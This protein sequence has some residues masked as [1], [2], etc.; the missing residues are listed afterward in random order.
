MISVTGLSK[1]YNSFYALCDVSI[2]IQ[3][4]EIF[5]LLG[6]NG[7]GKTTLLNCL[8]GLLY[9]TAG[10]I[11]FNG[12]CRNKDSLKIKKNLFY[13]P[14]MPFIYP[15]WTPEKYLKTIGA[16][17]EVRQIDIKT[18]I[19]YLLEEFNI[20]GL[21]TTPVQFFSRG[22]F[23]KLAVCGALITDAK[24]LLFDE[25]FASGID[26]GGIINLKK[27]L[28]MRS[29]D[30]NA[31]I[32]FS[33]QILDVTERISDRIAIVEKGKLV[34]CGRINEL[35]EQARLESGSLEDVFGQLMEN[36]KPNEENR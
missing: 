32:I 13:I 7:A 28:Q 36:K 24:Y 20:S 11:K 16:L 31:T 33:T 25:P 14:D 23:Y 21:I 9:P 6:A 12:L 8:T 26:A 10:E 30:E 2:E 34:G 19:E 4:G 27:H 1:K 22:E 17:Y 5:G 29:R 3:D 35:R 15:A 18:R